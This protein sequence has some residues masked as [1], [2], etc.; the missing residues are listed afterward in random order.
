MGIN[1]IEALN[2]KRFDKQQEVKIFLNNLNSITENRT[3]NFNIEETNFELTGLIDKFNRDTI[4]ISILSEVSSGKSTFL[5]ALVFNKPILESK[6]GETTSKIFHIKYDESYSIDGIKTESITNLKEQIAKENHKNLEV[7]NQDEEISAMQS[8]ITLPNKN[9]KKGI[10]L[11]DTPGFAT[12]KEK[13]IITLLKEVISKSDAT[14]LLLDISQGIKESEHLFIKKML[15]NIPLNKRFIVLN[16]YDTILDEDD[17]A[18]KTKEEIE[19]EISALIQN[20]ESTLQTLQQDSTQKI[21]SFHLSAKKALVGKVKNDTLR[22]QESRFPIFEEVFWKRVVE[23]KDE[24]FEDNIQLFNRLQ[25]KVKKAFREQKSIL[26]KEKRTLELKVNA[27][28]EN[29]SRI[30][31]LKRDIE[32]L[33]EL[34]KSTK[35][36]QKNIEAEEHKLLAD[37]L[38]ILKIN[39]TSELTSITYFQ[40]I[41]FWT[42]KNRYKNSILYGIKNARSY[43]IQHINKFILVSSKERGEMD[44]ILWSINQNL[45]QLIVVGKH[46]K[47]ID[48]SKM[49]DRVITRMENHITWDNSTLFALLKYNIITKKSKELE[50]SYLELIAEIS[51]I[52]RVNNNSIIKGRVERENYI[53]LVEEKIE[54]MQKMLEER[55]ILEKEI[56]DITLLIEEIDIWIG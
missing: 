2:Q 10:E 1:Q 45:T 37:I 52:K 41:K 48:L 9:L 31:T 44:S 30:L 3:F 13:K 49:M 5:N 11:Y 6:I 4:S 39:L 21:E 18:I 40:K 22:L 7:I 28:I 34:N 16:K 56:Q 54:K 29:Q 32:R 23:A 43:I 38:Y 36:R 42:L 51:S 17:L 50:P 55:Y 24:T 33:Q 14:I 46:N 27:T 35:D 25:E 20:I 12:L 26:E 19:E 15:R 53:V 8:V 47:K